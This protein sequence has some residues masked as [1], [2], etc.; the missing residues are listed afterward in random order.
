MNNLE[1]LIK[2]F[3]LAIEIIS[4]LKEIVETFIT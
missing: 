1:L 3:Q 4:L 2:L